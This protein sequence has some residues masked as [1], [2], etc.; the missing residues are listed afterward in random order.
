[1]IRLHLNLSWSISQLEAMTKIEISVKLS[2]KFD[3]KDFYGKIRKYVKKECDGSDAY[4]E[5]KESFKPWG[6]HSI[7]PTGIEYILWYDFNSETVSREKSEQRICEYLE[8]EIS[9]VTKARPKKE[10]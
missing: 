7:P 4:I 2:G 3:A 6:T 1:M 10:D 5:P 8:K 9:Y